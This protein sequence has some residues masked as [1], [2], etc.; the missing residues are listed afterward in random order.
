M[1][2]SNCSIYGCAMSTKKGKEQDIA[3]FGIPKK[4]DDYSVKWRE[5][6]VAIITRDRVVDESLRR[7]IQNRTLHICER[8]FP[9][10][11]VLQRKC[12]QL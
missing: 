1:P 3:M 7:Q 2:G 6:L 5:K 11:K 9:A 4:D 10:E 8:H 12:S